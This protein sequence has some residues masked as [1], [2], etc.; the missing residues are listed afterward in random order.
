M[1]LVERR[2]GLLFSV[3]FAIFVLFGISMTVIG[4]TLPRILD[5][6][7]WDYGTA[8]SVIAAGAI[9]YFLSTYAA[10]K[11]VEKIGPKA[12][13]SIGI[14]LV[15][16]GL[17]F[18]AMTPS[19]LL[20]LLLNGII[21]VG[22]GF[23]EIVV[24][25]T[26]FRIDKRGRALNLMHGAFS[27]GAVAGPFI[28]GF[29]MAW[30]LSW[31]LVYR[32]MAAIFGIILV[33]ACTLPFSLVPTDREAKAERREA[34][35]ERSPAYILGFVAL[36]LYVGVEIGVS[37]WTSEFFVRTFGLSEAA[38]SFMVSLFWLG[39]LAGRFGVPLLFPRAGPDRVLTTLAVGLSVSTGLLASSGY[40]GAA[41]MP[42]AIAAIGLAGLSCSAI[43]PSIVALAGRSFPAAQGEAIGFAV[44]GGGIGSFL[45]PYLMSRIARASGVLTG[46]AFYAGI[47]I[48]LAA[49]AFAYASAAKARYCALGRDSST[50]ITPKP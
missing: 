31:T 13:A 3:L 10:G 37:N 49:A 2:F 21:G 43:Y 25:W 4:A 44:A 20:N 5:D 32:G 34:R 7:G 35:L 12:A 15:V 9:G 38:G 46:F 33:V 41:A 45:F 8:G 47:A 22:Q 30:G 26:T 11:L 23:L 29:L 36:F 40:A 28:V 27:I 1:A 16:L 24:N 39:V 14:V 17:A 48:L 18:F 19:P 6:F 50:E 42:L